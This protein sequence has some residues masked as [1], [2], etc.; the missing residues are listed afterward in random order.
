MEPIKRTYQADMKLLME[1]IVNALKAIG[2]QPVGQ[3]H[4]LGH[5]SFRNNGKIYYAH[6]VE[7]DSNTESRLIVAPGLPNL[8]EKEINKEIEQTIKRLFREL[9]L[10]VA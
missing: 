5:I 1:M 9:D 4:E 10:I 2:Y 3:N 7:M 6:I 8:T